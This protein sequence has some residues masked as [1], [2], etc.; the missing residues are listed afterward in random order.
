MWTRGYCSIPSA[1]ALAAVF[2]ACADDPQSPAL[3]YPQSAASFVQSTSTSQGWTEQY[4]TGDPPAPRY[5][6][7]QAYDTAND[8]LILFSGED[9]TGLPRPTDVWVLTDATGIGGTPSWMELF[10]TGGPPFGRVFGTVVYA[11]G[12]NRII[13]FGGCSENCS[14]ALSDVWVLSNAN[15]TGGAPTWTQLFPSGAFGREEHAAAYD[16]GSN[17]MMVFGGALAFFGTDQNDVR[18]LTNADGTGGPPAWIQLAPSGTPPA[19]RRSLQTAAYDQANNRLILFGG[20]SAP[21]SST[22][23][24]YNDVWVLTNANG[25][26]GPPTW[27]QLTPAG[28]L[29]AARAAHSTHY[30][31]TT[32]QLIIFG[33]NNGDGSAIFND[34]WVLTNANGLG[35]TPMWT[36][37]SPGGT[38]PAARG[39]QSSGYSVGLNT[40]V[41]A[42]GGAGTL[43]ND[44]W[45]LTN[46][47]GTTYDFTGFFTPVDNP[48][49][50]E[51][52]VN[53][54]NAGRGIPVKFSLAGDQGL[55][56]FEPGYPR[57]VSSP[58]DNGDTQDAIEETTTSPAGLTYDAVTDQYT[59]VW[60]TQKAWA[61]RCGTFQLGLNDGTGHH[62]LFRFVR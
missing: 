13:V 22:V 2:T 7:G 18:V 52:V 46:A 48:G 9:D 61:G 50:N 49:A 26:G 17:R 6:A 31:P 39:V 44:V 3:G 57:F 29:P 15:G 27:M 25:L 21:N 16:P 51:D 55:D 59:Y 40:L 32:N 33:G 30:D 35:G 37:Q 14:P 60:K 24:P 10:P 43:F 8:R 56:I 34:V 5:S 36:Q 54:A 38:P 41:V 62:A 4:P 23:I 47:N 58:C 1:V 12:S 42:M 53:R 20:L 11:P 45:V 28:A 19:A